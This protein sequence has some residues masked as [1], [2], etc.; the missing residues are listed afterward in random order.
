MVRFLPAF[1]LLALG[2]VSIQASPAMTPRNARV[3]VTSPSEQQI[4]LD[5]MTNLIG[6]NATPAMVAN[7]NAP[8]ISTVITTQVVATDGLTG[9]PALLDPPKKASALAVNN[10]AITGSALTALETY[11][12]YSAAAY[13]LSGMSTWTCAERCSGYTQGTVM[14]AQFDDLLTNTVGYVAYNTAN[15]EIIVAYRGTMSVRSAI[16]D[17]QLIKADLA[18]SYTRISVAPGVEVHSGFLNA[19][20]ITQDRVAAAIAYIQS[21]VPGSKAYTITVTGHSLGGAIAMLSAIQLYD[22]LGQSAGSRIQVYTYGEPRVGNPAFAAW[23]YTLPFSSKIYRVTHLADIVP[24]LP[25]QFLG[26]LH[27]RSEFW[28][29]SA[30]TIGTCNDATGEDSHCA[31]SEFFTNIQDHLLG[32]FGI[33]FGPWC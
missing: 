24:H 12:S 26:F 28:I 23:V 27:H 9:P 10:I 6:R 8:A 3:T 1:T 5:Y 33:P 19:V 22:V 18:P 11:Q 25:P 7:I 31:D 29:N 16:T 32:Y 20:K 13:C 21:T 17:L 4:R 14:V 30:G 2:A 15:K